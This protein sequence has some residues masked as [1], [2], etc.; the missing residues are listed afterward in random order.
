MGGDPIN[1]TETEE[2]KVTMDTEAPPKARSSCSAASPRDLTRTRSTT[3][4]TWGS[5][6][7]AVLHPL[8]PRR[9]STPTRSPATRP[10]GVSAARKR[11]A[12]GTSRPKPCLSAC[13]VAAQRLPPRPPSAAS[14]AAITPGCVSSRWR[15]RSTSGQRTLID[16]LGRRLRRR[17]R[18]LEFNRLAERDADPPGPWY[19]P[20]EE[21][22]GSGDRARDHRCAGFE[23][24][25]RSSL[26]RVT[27]ARRVPYPGALRKQ[28]QQAAL[29][30]GSAAL[31]R[32]P[33]HRT[34]RA[35]PGKLRAE[36]AACPHGP[37][38]A[39]SYP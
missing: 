10:A 20:G 18:R 4:G 2:P 11:S 33:P 17:F 26:V 14:P 30:G 32:S 34:S 13:A 5:R 39:R 9:P 38:R 29:R 25:P 6:G 23:R 36:S 21:L 31:S 15:S 19:R 3:S 7:R 22:L 8:R 27:K 37:R 1:A 28:R 24:Q 16:E 12:R 35:E